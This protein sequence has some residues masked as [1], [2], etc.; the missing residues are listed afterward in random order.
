MVIYRGS[1][2]LK[3]TPRHRDRAATLKIGSTRWPIDFVKSAS[4]EVGQESKYTL[5]KFRWTANCGTYIFGVNVENIGYWYAG[6]IPIALSLGPVL[7]GYVPT[8]LSFSLFAVRNAAS[9]AYLPWSITD[10]PGWL[11]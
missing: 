8:E 3:L 9:S 7:L 6:W 10:D 11:R 1:Q 4:S 5:A 2:I